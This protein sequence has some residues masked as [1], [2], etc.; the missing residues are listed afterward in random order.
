MSVWIFFNL[1][2]LYRGFSKSIDFYPGN[3][4]FFDFTL[5]IFITGKRDFYPWDWEFLKSLD[6]HLRGSEIF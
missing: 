1:G 2:Y 6:F 5:E 4:G 3:W